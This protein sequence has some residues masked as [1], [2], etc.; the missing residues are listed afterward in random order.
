MRLAGLS[1][2]SAFLILTSCTVV[3]EEGPRPSPPPR[4]EQADCLAIYEPVCAVRRGERRT[5]GNACEAQRVRARI[6]HPGECE[7]ASRPDPIPSE[8]SCPMIYEP[9]CGVRNGEVRTFGNSCE[10]G[11]VGAEVLYEGECRPGAAP[12]PNRPRP[13]Y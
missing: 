13:R 9:V 11:S 7:P 1:L 5:Y 12:R 3:S 4:G 8:V 10:A 6:V 2:A